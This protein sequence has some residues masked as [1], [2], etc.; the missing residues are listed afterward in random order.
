MIVYGVKNKI[1]HQIIKRKEKMRQFIY[2]TRKQD[3][4]PSH[5]SDFMVV[6]PFSFLIYIIFNTI[7]GYQY[8]NG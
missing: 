6:S 3:G 5:S 7:R 8:H 1:N 4:D 2:G